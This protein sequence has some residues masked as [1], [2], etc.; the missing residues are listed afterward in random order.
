MSLLTAQGIASVAVPLLRR[1]LKLPRTVTMI[2]GGDFSGP[3]GSTITVRVPTPTAAR[4]QSSAGADITFD[5]IDEVAAD[6]TLSHLY[7]AHLITDE[8]ANLQLEDF[9]RQ[10][11]VPQVAS[12]AIGAENALATVMNNLTESADVEFAFTS[13]DD[14]TADTMLAAREYLSEND[15][16]DDDRWAAVSPSIATRILHMLDKVNESG[17][18]DALR[19]AIIGRVYGFNVVES[20]AIADGTAVFYH[21]SGFAFA[22]RTPTAPR[23]DSADSATQNDGGLA[24][25]AILQYVPTKLSEASVISTFAGATAVIDENDESGASDFA[26]PDD[27]LRFIRVGTGESSS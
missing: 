27:R 17:S 7:N 1:Q 22:N 16:P 12:V 26:S 18:G 13:S 8:E 3:N 20:S 9:A 15:V 14:D 6:V 2:S 10:I 11:L 4:T 24:L 19:S 25:R 23:S 21:R 5:A